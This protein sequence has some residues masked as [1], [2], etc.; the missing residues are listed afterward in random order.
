V[1]QD[2][3]VALLENVIKTRTPEEKQAAITTLATLPPQKTEKLFTQLLDQMQ[4][5]KLPVEIQ[6][7]LSDAIDST[8]SKMLK[9]RYLQLSRNASPD[10]LK[11]I[12]AGALMG[13]DPDK[14]GR[15]FWNHPTVQCIRCHA[16]D[17]QGG[18]AGPR[19]NGVAGRLSKD[20]LLEALIEPSARIAPGFGMVS[21]ELKNREKIN[22]I[23]QQEKPGA[24]IVKVGSKPDTTI[25]KTDVT[26][27]VNYPSSMPQMH[28]LLSK[29]EIRDVVSF[30][31]TLQKE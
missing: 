31:S 13:G 24:F 25:N 3:Q 26:N 30:L 18:T 7:E 20:Q 17:D 14:G 10:S 8:G 15:I 2:L 11:S 22:G 1:S 28:L 12:Y 5:R 27:R 16:F 4:Q 6:F 29:K 23:L 21:L 19:L 9:D